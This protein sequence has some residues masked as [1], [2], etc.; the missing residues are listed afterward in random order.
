MLA[1]LSRY[2]AQLSHPMTMRLPNGLIE[3]GERVFGLAPVKG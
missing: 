2:G 3:G 1:T